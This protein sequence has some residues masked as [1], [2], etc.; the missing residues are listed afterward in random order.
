MVWYG[1]HVVWSGEVCVL[2]VVRYVEGDDMCE[3]LMI[4]WGLEMGISGKV[5][6]VRYVMGDDHVRTTALQTIM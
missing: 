6:G 1:A 2:C 3:Y 4:M 5:C